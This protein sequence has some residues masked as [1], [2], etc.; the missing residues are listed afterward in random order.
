MM[1]KTAAYLFTALFTAVCL[2]FSLG[3]LLPGA[4]D[5][6]GE[7]MPA[8][9]TDGRINDDFGNLFE[10]WFSKN[11]AFHDAVTDFYAGLKLALF[12]EGN[13]QVVAG[14]DDFLFFDDTTADYIGSDP[15]T[16]EEIQ[17]IAEGL[18]ALNR[19]VTE[20]GG[21]FLFVCAP[22]KNTVYPEYMPDRYRKNPGETDLDRLYTVLESTGIPYIDLRPVLEAHKSDGLLYHRRDTHW[23]GLGAGTA[24]GAIADAMGFE[25]C[26]L[27]GRGPVT[28]QD[29]EGDLDAL[30]FPGKIM[31]DENTTWDFTGLYVY[32]SAFATPM[33]LVITARGGGEGKLLMFRDSFANAL[34]PFAASSF[35]EI[36]LER[37]TPY[38]TA[39][40]AQ[41]HPDY[42]IVEIA[43][44]N[45]RELSGHLGL[46]TPAEGES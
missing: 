22:N 35:A 31:Y 11:F 27:T 45:L 5:S 6:D 3:L 21:K 7:R 40:I 34:I 30:L 24:F 10:E 12:D 13:D 14:K 2:I 18:A 33:D 9:L 1:K 20:N 46:N 36:R 8:L 16:D 44:R 32:T 43:E 4:A 38:Q 23:N 41:N 19:T 37:G 15:M 42:V 39:Q 29:F 17:R 25:I 28:T 26:D